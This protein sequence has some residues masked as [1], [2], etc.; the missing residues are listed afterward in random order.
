[1]YVALQGGGLYF[2]PSNRAIMFLGNYTANTWVN[3]TLGYSGPTVNADRNLGYWLDGTGHTV[4]LNSYGSTDTSGYVYTYYPFGHD[5][6][7]GKTDMSSTGLT[8][9]AKVVRLR[10]TVEAISWYPYNDTTTITVDSYPYQKTVQKVTKSW[11]RI[12]LA[13]LKAKLDALA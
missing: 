9:K 8:W 1:F 10:N 11:G 7:L 3:I 2:C 12:T 5:F 4:N 6:Y 13:E